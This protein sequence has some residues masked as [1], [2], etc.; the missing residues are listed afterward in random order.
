M[1]LFY[2]AWKATRYATHIAE[3]AITDLG[4]WAITDHTGTVKL[5]ANLPRWALSTH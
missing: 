3:K 2:V 1:G 4:R 5:L